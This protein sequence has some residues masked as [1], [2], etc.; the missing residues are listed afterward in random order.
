LVF[1]WRIGGGLVEVLV[2]NL[3]SQTANNQNNTKKLHP[4]GG[5][6]R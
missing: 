1:G 5:G 2:Y 3:F 6:W 4:S